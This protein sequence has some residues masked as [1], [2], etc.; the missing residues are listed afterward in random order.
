MDRM[1]PYI[2]I[3]ILHLLLTIEECTN[4]TQSAIIELWSDSNVVPASYVRLA[5]KCGDLAR[6]SVYILCTKRNRSIVSP[7]RVSCRCNNLSW[8]LCSYFVWMNYK[9]AVDWSTSCS[10]HILCTKSDRSIVS[11]LRVSRRCN[12]SL[13]FNIHSPY[14]FFLQCLDDNIFD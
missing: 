10:V 3:Q 11:P 1:C 12:N 7:L 9:L 14:S 4:D 5:T 8:R 2:T 13:C 6:C